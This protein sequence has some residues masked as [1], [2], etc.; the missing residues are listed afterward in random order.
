MY[1]LYMYQP[2]SIQS[3]SKGQ[4]SKM[5]NGHP[6]RV[7]SGSGM[8][9]NASKEQ[10]KKIEKAMKKGSGTTIMLD[11]FQQNEMSG[12]GI[13]SAFKKLGSF[14]K[15]NKEAFR[16]LA[17]SL[18]QS[19]N[20]LI[21][22]AAMKALDEGVDPALVSAYANMSSSALQGPRQQGQ[23]FIK[24]LN[25]FV[26]TPAMKTVRKAFRPLGQAMLT[27]GQDLAM[28]G[29]EQASEQAMSQMTGQGFIKKLNKFVK[30]PAVRTV[31][32][33]FRP[34]GQA[35]LTSGQDL[36][37]QGLEQAS[38]QAM[39]QMTGMGYG[40][41]LRPAGYDRDGRYGGSLYSFNNRINRAM[42]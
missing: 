19:G 39:S 36:A 30:T 28:Q 31:R 1:I 9:F 8:N 11:P 17:K 22:E 16:P 34:L 21:A 10:I 18:K 24:K 41:A 37:M 40:G 4:I 3:L 20:Q 33:A 27:S 35:M 25:K 15:G 42:Q 13:K 23:G 26:K 7:K 6:V 29:L 2:V 32:K 12:S 14:V 5:L 38:E